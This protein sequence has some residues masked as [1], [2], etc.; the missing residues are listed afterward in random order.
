MKAS[1]RVAYSMGVCAAR[2]EWNVDF[3][4]CDYGSRYMIEWQSTDTMTEARDIGFCVRLGD[5]WYRAPR[6]S[7]LPYTEESVFI[8]DA[9]CEALNTLECDFEGDENWDGTHRFMSADPN[10][11]EVLYH[12]G[13]IDGDALNIYPPEPEQASA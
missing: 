1:R 13:F 11:M 2:K 8:A 10:P 4:P 9:V 3:F 5:R 6:P 7:H 12:H